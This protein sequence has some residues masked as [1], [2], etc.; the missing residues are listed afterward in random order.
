MKELHP[1]SVHPVADSLLVL[2]VIVGYWFLR[3]QVF[4]ATVEL[5]SEDWNR[6]SYNTTRLSVLIEI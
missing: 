1:H 4:K 5:G 2:M 3:L 6:A